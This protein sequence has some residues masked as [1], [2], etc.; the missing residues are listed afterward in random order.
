MATDALS[1]PPCAVTSDSDGGAS[2]TPGASVSVVE[3]G[4][5]PAAVAEGVEGVE[6]VGAP[7][8]LGAADVEV[9]AAPGAAAV[10]LAAAAR[11]G[12]THVFC[13]ST[14]RAGTAART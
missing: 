7:G 8:S 1:T 10:C 13:F 11:A 3:T 2:S 5:V 9:D 12:F 14:G 6:V 4:G